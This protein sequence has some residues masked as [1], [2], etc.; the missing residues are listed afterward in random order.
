MG[1]LPNQPTLV[2]PSNYGQTGE[3]SEGHALGESGRAE[4]RVDAVGAGKE[5]GHEAGEPVNGAG[6]GGGAERIAPRVGGQRRPP[7]IIQR[8]EAQRH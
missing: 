8:R 7:R 4:L 6:E 3:G 2:R 1:T 5:N